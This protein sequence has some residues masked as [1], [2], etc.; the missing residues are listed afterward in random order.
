M[1]K[2]VSIAISYEAHNKAECPECGKLCVLEDY[3][4]ERKWRH[5]DVFQ[6]Q[7]FLTCS[8][9]RIRC[10]EHG[11]KTID[12]PFA[13][14]L[15]SYTELFAFHII[16]LLQNAKS[17]KA[18]CNLTQTSWNMIM[19]IQKDAVERALASRNLEGI[20]TLGI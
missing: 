20:E 11:V 13:K 8:V 16:T 15:V 1:T 9:P 12:V 10:S 6:Y 7:T 18:V 17:I 5:L 19:S 3:R 14:S 4:K 2:T